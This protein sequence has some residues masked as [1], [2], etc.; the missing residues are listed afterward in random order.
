MPSLFGVDIAGIINREMGPGLLALTLIQVSEGARNADATQGLTLT[1]T[2]HS[3]R[4]FIED[5]TLGQLGLELGAG[6]LIRAGDKKITLLGAS[7][8]VVPQPGWKVTLEGTTYNI[9]AIVTRDP[10]AATYVLLGR[11]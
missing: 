10:A 1:E 6:V 3:G 8:T 11:R 9:E 2:S 7:V 5:W 4:G